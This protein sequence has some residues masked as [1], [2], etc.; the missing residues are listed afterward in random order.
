MSLPKLALILSPCPM[1]EQ[2]IFLIKDK[3]LL[4]FLIA[5][6]ALLLSG[7]LA[8]HNTDIEMI[9][10]LVLGGLCG[11]V[12]IYDVPMVNYRDP[13]KRRIRQFLS[14]RRKVF[15][16]LL[17]IFLAPFALMVLSKLS[18][19]LFALT[20]LLGV[21]YSY[22]IRINNQLIRLKNFLFLKNFLI[23]ISWG[24]LVL[25]GAGSFDHTVALLITVFASI[26]VFI[27]SMIRD[28]SDVSFDK[29][30]GVQSFPV[31]FGVSNT[32]R[33]MHLVNVGSLAIG[34]FTNSGTNLLILVSIIVGWR[35]INLSM[36]KEDHM[37]KIWLQKF[38]LLTCSLFFVI[39]LI[40]YIWT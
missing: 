39:L 1:T 18:F 34:M 35:F 32:L 8:T 19:F 7:S 9:S 3:R 6:L 17:L 22:P 25:I 37:P 33:F 23:G 16:T 38:N 31:V 5:T 2:P 29:N 10:V 36:I 20:A 27:G 30:R 12:L 4:Q 28:L 40:Q 24:A 21:L 13:L 14:H 26:Q 11:V 15:Y